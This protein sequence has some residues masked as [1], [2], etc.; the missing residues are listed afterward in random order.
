MGI[1]S[2]FCWWMLSSYLHVLHQVLSLQQSL[3]V[4]VALCGSIISTLSSQCFLGLVLK[5]T[6]PSPPKVQWHLCHKNQSCPQEM[7]VLKTKLLHLSTTYFQACHSIHS[8]LCFMVLYNLLMETL[9]LLRFSSFQCSS[10]HSICIS[11]LSSSNSLGNLNLSSQRS[12]SLL[13]SLPQ[14][15][16]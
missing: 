15:L 13:L 6:L 2:L 4:I 8:F 3:P 11:F 10:F 16:H 14:L 1:Y 9:L 7:L 5:K 12:L